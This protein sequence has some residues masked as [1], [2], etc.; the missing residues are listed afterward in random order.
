[1]DGIKVKSGES[2]KHAF[3]LAIALIAVSAFAKDPA[4]PTVGLLHHTTENSSLQYSC[5]LRGKSL[6]CEMTQSFVRR[7]LNDADIPK[8]RE[9]LSVEMAKLSF[10]QGDCK[11]T[12]KGGKEFEARLKDPSSIPSDDKLRFGQMTQ[13]EKDTVLEMFRLYENVCKTNSLA[14]KQALGEHLLNEEAGLCRV[15]SHHWK[16]TFRYQASGAGPAWISDSE[17]RGDCGVVQ[18]NRFEL[19][20]DAAT[21]TFWNYVSRK[22]VSNPTGE[23][24]ILGGK[25]SNL[26]EGTYSYTWKSRELYLSCKKIVFSVL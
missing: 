14:A 26:D 16:E 10:S 13:A 25:C 1:M 7:Q 11:S 2:M 17:P 23:L 9:A 20:K 21:S 4:Y 24:L 15:G 22:A 6:E 8:K 19:A 5:V 18:L 3:N 12:L